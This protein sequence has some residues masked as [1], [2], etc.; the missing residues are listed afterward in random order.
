V[1]YKEILQTYLNSTPKNTSE[2]DL[3]PRGTESLLTSVEF[4]SRRWGGVEACTGVW[5]G[6]MRER[7]HWGDLGVDGRITLRWIFKK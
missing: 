5:W 4:A 3:F 2:T 1:G 7:D 6:S